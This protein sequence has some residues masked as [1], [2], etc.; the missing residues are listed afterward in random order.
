MVNYWI[1]T[2]KVIDKE[3]ILKIFESCD[4]ETVNNVIELVKSF[5]NV[6]ENCIAKLLEV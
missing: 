1:E 6:P 3:E 5:P 2:I 4:R